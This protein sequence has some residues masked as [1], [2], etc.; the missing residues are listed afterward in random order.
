MFPKTKDLLLKK[1]IRLYNNIAIVPDC[2]CRLLAELEVTNFSI[3]NHKLI[4]YIDKV[5][6][7]FNNA[8]EG[9]AARAN[10][11]GGLEEAHIITFYLPN[12]RFQFTSNS[13]VCSQRIERETESNREIFK[14][15]EARCI[16]VAVDNN[17][18]IR[19]K[20]LQD[21]LDWLNPEN[22]NTGTLITAVGE[23]YPSKL[24]ESQNP[25]LPTISLDSALERL[26]ILSWLL[27][28]A[29]GGYIQPLYVVGCHL[30]Q[31][32]DF[33][34]QIPH[35]IA[36][37]SQTTPLERLGGSWVVEDSDIKAYLACLPVLERMMQQPFWQEAFDFI[38]A[39]YFQAI[40]PG[41]VAWQVAA[42]AISAALERISYT[43][44]VEEESDT[45]KRDNNNLLFKD[46]K[47][48]EEKSRYKQFWK[49]ND[50]SYRS[51]DGK[52]SYFSQRVIR[53]SVL[54]ERIG[55]D[56]ARDLNLI[57]AFISIRNNAVHPISSDTT[58]EERN[59]LIHKATQWLD[60][61]L[62]WR[63]GYCGSYRD[64]PDNK[65]YATEQRYKL[66]LR[67]SQW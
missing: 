46:N 14:G 18:T 57:Q 67:N 47:N 44:L 19:L 38:L 48:E 53:L 43:I 36:L 10:Y 30:N 1:R 27:S 23:L 25:P 65:G 45:G 37:A 21:S 55:L 40:Q 7:H 32:Q 15:E 64:R 3:P 56:E 50:Y 63:L 22:R 6:R 51:P 16:K 5:F 33:S 2:Q 8:I 26:K 13:Q 41:T 62:L 35:A 20:I 59:K 54:F 52:N 29:N 66:R 24:E 49:C 17:W 31:D 12:T 28:Y 11:E 9:T 34:A 39:Q 60:E 58:M 4:G 61:V 42:S